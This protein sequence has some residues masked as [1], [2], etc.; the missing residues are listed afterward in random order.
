MDTLKNQQRLDVNNLG[1]LG[2]LSEYDFERIFDKVNHNDLNDKEKCWIW[3]GSIK[4]IRKGHQHVS[5]NFNGKPVKVHRLMYHNF[6]EDVPEYDHAN[7]G[8]IVLHKCSHENNGKCINP[9]HMKLGTSKENT[10]DA[11]KAKTLTLLKS[12]EANPNSKLTDIKIQE[13]MDLK[14]SGRSQKDIAA[15]YGIHQAQVSRYWNNKT[16]K[17]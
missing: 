3:Q 5:F 17:I 14:G 11:M 10:N 13:I 7:I 4:D 8:L 15:E 1:K 12:G 9:W 16:R 6:I 2:K